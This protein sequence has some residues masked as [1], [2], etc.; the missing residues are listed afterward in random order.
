MHS[1]T[2]ILYVVAAAAKDRLPPPVQ[3]ATYISVIKIPADIFP[4]QKPL[5]A[6]F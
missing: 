4:L 2:G 6:V 1:N 5:V 3:I